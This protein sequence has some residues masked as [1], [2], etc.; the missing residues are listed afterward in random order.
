MF[1]KT[2]S[3]ERSLQVTGIVFG[4]SSLFKFGCDGMTFVRVIIKL[5]EVAGHAHI[6]YPITLTLFII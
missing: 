6:L 5:V 2:H 3:N 4:D 1:D